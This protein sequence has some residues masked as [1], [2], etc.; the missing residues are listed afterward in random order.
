VSA[1]DRATPYALVLGTI[2]AERFP[3]LRD[4]IAA[5]GRDPR[6]RDAFLMVRE[7]VELLR[8]LEPEEGLGE[9]IAAMAAFLH[10]S[11]LYW[12]DGQRTIAVGEEGLEHALAGADPGVQEPAGQSFG[13]PSA[14]LQLPPLRVWGIPVEGEAAEP[15]DGW[16]VSPSGATLTVLAIFGI[17]PGRAGFTAVE[18]A[19]LR[20]SLLERADGT[21]LFSPALPGA[22]RAGLASIVGA[23]ELLE[24]AWR[25]RS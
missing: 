22:A 20:P 1:P 6:D 16:F 25:L 23:E 12:M 5:A 11:Y 17:H 9:A 3:A 21:A 10:Q 2:A 7:V 24:L 4:G 19:G 15:L 18:V 8:E 14:Y 13:L